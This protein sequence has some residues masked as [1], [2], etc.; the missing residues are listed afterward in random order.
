MRPR[1]YRPCPMTLFGEGPAPSFVMVPVGGRYDRPVQD[2]RRTTA[3]AIDAN[4]A[5]GLV[6]LSWAD[7]HETTYDAV[8]LRWLCPCAFCRGEAGM[9]GWLD[10]KPELTPEQ[11]RLVDMALVGAY[12]IQPTWGD[13]HHTGYH[14]FNLLRDHCPCDECTRDRAQTHATHAGGAR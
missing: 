3:V 13:G 5:A 1:A 14:S 2:K 10:T 9:P 7:G 12:A 6:K 4:R 11:T 8:T